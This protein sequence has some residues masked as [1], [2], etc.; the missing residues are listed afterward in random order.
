[1]H[2]LD[3]GETYGVGTLPHPYVGLGL[4]SKHFKMSQTLKGFSLK[5][6]VWFV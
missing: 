6:Q 4:H 2:V 5:S 1:M 3:R